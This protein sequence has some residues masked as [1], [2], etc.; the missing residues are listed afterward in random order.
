MQNL[1]DTLMGVTISELTQVQQTIKQIKTIKAK[2]TLTVGGNCVVVQKTKRTPGVIEKL[3]QTRAVVSML[4]RKYTV[5][6]SMLE[7]A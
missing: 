3:N 2:S 6:F 5:P 1:T 4:G 7:A